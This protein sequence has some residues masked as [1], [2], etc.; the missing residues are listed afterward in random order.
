MASEDIGPR[1][2]P[3]TYAL[4]EETSRYLPSTSV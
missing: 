2:E 1:A 3:T 4:L